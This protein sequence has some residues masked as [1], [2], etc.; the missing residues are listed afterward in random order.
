MTSDEITQSQA[1]LNNIASYNAAYTEELN[2]NNIGRSRWNSG[3]YR[4]PFGEQQPVTLQTF[5]DWLNA[6]DAS[7]QIKKG[8]L[9]VE[10]AKYN[11]FMAG[12]SA[13]DA[14]DKARADEAFRLANP[15]IVAKIESDKLIAATDTENKKLMQG[16]TK[17]YIIGAIVLV[18]IV[19]G[20]YFLRKK[21]SK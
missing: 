21:F 11:D 12:I 18:V 7:L 5:A 15:A 19:I 1:I 17:Y 3:D 10:K 20:I 16:T 13:K 6:S 2:Q 4:L 8:L 14:S 9:D